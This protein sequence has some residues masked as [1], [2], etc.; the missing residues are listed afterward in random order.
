[1]LTERRV[2]RRRARHA[3]PNARATLAHRAGNDVGREPC[4]LALR[5]DL[6]AGRTGRL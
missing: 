6:L 3:R 1:M 4:G 5:R 2:N